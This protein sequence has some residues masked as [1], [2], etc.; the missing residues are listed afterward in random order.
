MTHRFSIITPFANASKYYDT[1]IESLIASAK[2][3]KNSFELILIDNNTNTLDFD[4]TFSKI[5]S[6]LSIHTR[7]IK[8]RDIPSS[9]AARNYG[10]NFSSSS[11]LCFVDIDCIF[12][13]SWM[14]QINIYFSSSSLEMIC[15]SIICYCEN[16][17]PFTIYDDLVYLNRSFYKGFPIGQTANLV[18]PKEIFEAC[19]QFSDATSGADIL[20]CKKAIDMGYTIIENPSLRLLHPL[21]TSLKALFSKIK[22]VSKGQRPTSSYKTFLACIK[23][24]CCLFLLL[25]FWLFLLLLFKSNYFKTTSMF[26]ILKCI[27]AGSLFS[28][29]FRVLRT[30]NLIIFLLS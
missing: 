19:N 23:S 12:T 28:F 21:R 1:Y 4:P 20:F 16:D 30:F 15:G 7:Q 2:Y 24:F 26:M 25:D 18:C 6:P 8:Y 10:A 27:I 22:R 13:T 9:Y 29:S 11:L 3:D 17:S 5:L 14:E